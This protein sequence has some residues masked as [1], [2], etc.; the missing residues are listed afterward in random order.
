MFTRILVP[1]DGS[2]LAETVLSEAVRLA[3]LH[4]A[5]LWLLRVAVAHAALRSDPADAQLR[6]VHEAEE[7]LS[8]LKDRLE[9]DMSLQTAVRYGQAAE[10]IVDHAAANQVDLIL[11]A[12][13]GRTGLA[14][15][16][17]GSVAEQVI[18]HTPCP[19]LLYRAAPD[20][21]VPP[22]RVDP[23]RR[24]AAIDPPVRPVTLRKILCPVDFAE[25]S[26]AALGVAGDLAERFQAELIVLHVVYDPVDAL[27]GR[28]PHPPL[29]RLKL[30]LIRQA[31]SLTEERVRQKLAHLPSAAVVVVAGVPD[32]EILRYV[33]DHDVDLIVMAAETLTGPEYVHLQS[34]SERLIRSAPC[35]VL[36]LR[37]RVAAEALIP[38]GAAG[39]R[40]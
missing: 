5:E 33:R 7:Y 37:G 31:E 26:E 23:Q 39:C 16:I 35:P 18:R 38:A 40:G 21:L 24:P 11:M 32:A 34:T 36:S 3:R 12:T 10:E 15:A 4:L 20:Q 30:E 13:H 2:R 6:A 25:A 19:I 29:E 22:S 1:L 27:V 9:R 8:T 28:L 17:L 14:H